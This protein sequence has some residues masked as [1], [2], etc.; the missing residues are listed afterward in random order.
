MTPRVVDESQ[1]PAELDAEIRRGLCVC[2]PPDVPIFSVGRAW[3]GS[4]P[5]FSVV[6]DEG[7]QVL[8]HV[9]VV[10]RTIRVG[11]TSIRV[12]GVQNVYVLPE[13][14][15][16]G[17]ARAVMVEAMNEAG[18]RGFDMGLLFCVPKLEKVYADC[19]WQSLGPR[20]VVRVED[21]REIPIP[22]KNIAMFFPLTVAAFPDG[23]IHLCGNDW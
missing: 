6:L 4:A 3:H 10:D 22:A 14:R 5:V 7:L 18:R 8:A 1:M 20:D 21:G 23:L 13:A 2:F 12:A 19:G 9:G 17:L 15:G 11:Q 16:R